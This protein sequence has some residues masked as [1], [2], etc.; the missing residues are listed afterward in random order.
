MICQQELPLQ[1]DIGLSAMLWEYFL[2]LAEGRE[3]LQNGGIF[4]VD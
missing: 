3:P 2:I 1:K 4:S